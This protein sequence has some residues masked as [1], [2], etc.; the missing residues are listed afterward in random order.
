MFISSGIRHD[1]VVAD[2][3][4]GNRFVDQ[5]VRYHVSG[6]IKLAPEHNDIEVLGLVNKPSVHSMM[7]FREMFLRA[8]D[9]FSKRYFMTYYL[10]AAHPGCTLPKM[11]QLKSFV[12]S[13]LK[14]MPKQVQIFTPTPSTLSTAMYYCGT[15]LNGKKIYCEKTIEGMTRQKQVLKKDEKRRFRR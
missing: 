11:Q 1:M 2:R 10:M 3:K 14:I 13:K 9:K 15:D 6:Q 4:N 5:L 7:I 8:C 12:I